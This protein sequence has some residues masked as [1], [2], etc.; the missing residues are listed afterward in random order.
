M[1]DRL[2]RDGGSAAF[3]ERMRFVGGFEGFC[4]IVSCCAT[5]IVEG[6]TV[7]AFNTIPTIRMLA[8]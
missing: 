5:L 2:G 8:W 7:L 4:L 3:E 1:W 6:K